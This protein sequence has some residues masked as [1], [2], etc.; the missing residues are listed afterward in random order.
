MQPMLTSFVHEP[1]KA[2]ARFLNILLEPLYE[3]TSRSISFMTGMDAIQAFEEYAE[4]GFLQST[5]LF[6]TVQIHDIYVI[7]SHDFMIE[8]LEHFLRNHAPNK[9]IQGISTSTIIQLVQLILQTQYLLHENKLY[10]QIAGSPLNTRLT[11]TLANIYLFYWHRD[12]VS[13]LKNNK[14]EIFGRCS[15]QFIFTW[16]ESEDE[17][18]ALL[19]PMIMDHFK[20]AHIRITTSTGHQIYYFDA[21]ISHHEGVLQTNVYHQPNLEPYSLPY[22][23]DTTKRQDHLF[24]LRAALI[25][26]VL[27][28]SNI[29]EFENERFYIEL[30]FLINDAT[31]NFIEETIRTFFFEFHPYY[32]DLFF[33]QEAYNR[34]RR[35]VQ[36]YHQQRTKYHIRHK[37]QRQKR[38]Q[39]QLLPSNDKQQKKRS[40]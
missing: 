9:Q 16:N 31:L 21:K 11:Q 4:Q 12:L 2:I 18:Q 27:Y 36:K 39:L 10:Q 1:I 20:N 22:V 19:N 3:Q 34:F 15:N 35:N 40:I 37:K 14:K 28:C 17:L 5:T 23:Y 24:L 33:D 29:D 8:A 7:F 6:V 30:S 25:R 32:T 26:A 38:R 13:I